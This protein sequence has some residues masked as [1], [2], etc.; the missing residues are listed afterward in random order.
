MVR[1]VLSTMFLV[2]ASPAWADWEGCREAWKGKLWEQAFEACHAEAVKADKGEGNWWAWNRVASLYKSGK[3]TARNYPE[4]LR[5]YRK[6]AEKRRSGR[7]M[8]SVGYMYFKGWGVPHNED[9]AMRWFR[10]SAERGFYMGQYNYGFRLV[11]DAVKGKGTSDDLV[12]GYMYLI[13][14]R[15]Q[16][17]GSVRFREEA[18]GHWMHIAEKWLTYSQID[19]AKRRA[20]KWKKA[21]K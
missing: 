15:Q 13:L 5:W 6:S 12:N 18:V 10:K 19:E 1:I 20:R 2:L 16:N 9:E 14:S 11:A 3:G 7:G 17:K 8:N 4:A 21:T